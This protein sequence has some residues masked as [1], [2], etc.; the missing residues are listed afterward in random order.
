MNYYPTPLYPK[1]ERAYMVLSRRELKRLLAKM[2]AD[3]KRKESDTIILRSHVGKTQAASSEAL[4]FRFN[5][6]ALYPEQ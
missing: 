5:Y 3:G 1:D 6:T 2:D 4:Q